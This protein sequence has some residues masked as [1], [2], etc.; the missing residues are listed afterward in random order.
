[1]DE[2]HLSTKCAEAGEDPRLSQEDVD[3]GRPGGDPVA[4]GEG[5]SSPVGVMAVRPPVPGPK[6]GLAPIRSRHT[7]EELRR[8]RSRGRAGPLTVAF[9]PQ[10]AWSGSEVAYAINRQVGNAVIRNRLRR[11]LRS[12]L[13]GLAPSLPAG[14]YLVRTGPDAPLLAFD[15]LKVAMS[16]ALGQAT[17]RED[18]RA[19]V[20]IAGG[21]ARR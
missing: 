4:P 17:R 21:E 16:R 15:E 7:F 8:T 6:K 18:G 14:A 20:A 5:T 13:A 12:I 11:R 19:V 10:N 2:A 3:E 1:M 9:V